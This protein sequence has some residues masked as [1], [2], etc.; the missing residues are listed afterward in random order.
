M[1]PWSLL[2]E[3]TLVWLAWGVAAI[4]ERGLSDQR[5]GVPDPDR[6]GVSLVPI[7]PVFPLAAWS[8]AI[9]V[10]RVVAPW[11]TRAVASTHALL[12]VVFVGAAARDLL[13]LR[14][15]RRRR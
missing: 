14:A 12:G 1:T 4:V 11:G 5:Q 13:R 6:H 3:V 9:L 10:D 8:F 7:L 15:L 2:M